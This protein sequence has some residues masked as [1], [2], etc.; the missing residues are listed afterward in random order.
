MAYVDYIEDITEKTEEALRRVWFSVR[1][2]CPYRDKTRSYKDWW[3]DLR[4]EVDDLG[5]ILDSLGLK[6]QER[7]EESFDS[8]GSSAREECPY[9]YETDRYDDWWNDLAKDLH[10]ISEEIK[11]L[12]KQEDN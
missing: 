11:Y 3:R 10:V 7:I 1:Q 6:E 4:E 5:S 2:K 12:K 8:L 9:H